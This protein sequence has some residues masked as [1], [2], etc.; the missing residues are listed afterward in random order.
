MN[1]CR[2]CLNS[3]KR[4]KPDPAFWSKVKT[5]DSV[6]ADL[7]TAT[8]TVL[9]FRALGSTVGIPIFGGI[10]NAGLAGREPN[11]EAFAHAIPLV[12]LAGVPVALVSIVLALR[13]Q[14][15]PLRDG[16]LD[17]PTTELTRTGRK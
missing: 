16:S 1:L 5:Y 8:S 12:F 3:T 10:L 4:R 13:L 2:V 14:D 9:L 17:P 11:A 7:G 15:R 6:K